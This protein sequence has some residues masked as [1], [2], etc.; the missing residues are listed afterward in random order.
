MNMWR[1]F[2][3]HTT[4]W[5]WAVFVMTGVFTV[6]LYTYYWRDNSA[7]A[8]FADII[9][10]TPRRVA[11][12]HEYRLTLRGPLGDSIIQ[13]EPGRVRFIASPCAGKHC[14]RAG[15]QSHPGD[16]AACLPNRISIRTLRDTQ[17]FDSLVF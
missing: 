16:F 13:V 1:E 10:E 9:M 4:G 12:D 8:K 7:E 15:W 6:S 11:L 3:S 17:Q 5:D 2:L 14:I